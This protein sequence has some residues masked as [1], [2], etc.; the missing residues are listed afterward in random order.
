M[1]FIDNVLPDTAYVGEHYF[2]R[3]D[4][5]RGKQR[6][7]EE[8]AAFPMPRIVDDALF[9]A[10]QEKLD[11]QHPLKNPAAIRPQRGYADGSRP[12]RRA[13]G[14]AA[15]AIRQLPDLSRLSMLEEI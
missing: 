6:P 7:R 1:Q 14:A 2:N 5:R 8:W 13:P 9:Y 3:N 10:A 15:Q 4:S 12:V 11:R